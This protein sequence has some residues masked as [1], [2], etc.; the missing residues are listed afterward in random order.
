[1]YANPTLFTFPGITHSYAIGVD[2]AGGRR[3]WV[4]DALGR[5][6]YADSADGVTPPSDAW[7][8]VTAAFPQRG[9]TSVVVSHADPRQLWVT[10]AGLASDNIWSSDDNGATWVNRHD[11]YLPT[12][13]A[14]DFNTDFGP[15][16]PHPLYPYLYLTEIAGTALTTPPT[17]FSVD[18]GGT[19]WPR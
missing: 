13:P 4:G 12:S 15:T 6:L 18:S 3:V 11:A 19:W 5:V 17:F 2:D 14:A 9:I 1:V 7:T 8:Q 10:F 16:T